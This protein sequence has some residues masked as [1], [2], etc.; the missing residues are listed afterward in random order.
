MVSPSLPTRDL[1]ASLR[2]IMQ[3]LKRMMLTF[4]IGVA[5]RAAIALFT[6]PAAIEWYARPGFATPVSCAE[7][8]ASSLAMLRQTVL[9]AAGGLGLV[10]VLATEIRRIL[11]AR[12][13]PPPPAP[14]ASG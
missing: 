1:R 2:A 9:G 6:V 4:L 7:P 10:L 8:V 5:L 3:A 13:A 14:A 11:K 12:K